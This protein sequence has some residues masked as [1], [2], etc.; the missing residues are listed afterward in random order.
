MLHFIYENKHGLGMRVISLKSHIHKLNNRLQPTCAKWPI[1]SYT[2]GKDFN[3]SAI[4]IKFAGHEEDFPGVDAYTKI[5]CR[6]KLKLT[7]F[8]ALYSIL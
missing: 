4:V 7:D 5:K 3:V 8:T 6:I 1:S 2:K